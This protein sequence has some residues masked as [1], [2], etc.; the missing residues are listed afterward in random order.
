MFFKDLIYIYLLI[1]IV[2][3]INKN[4]I[5]DYSMCSKGVRL[6]LSYRIIR[7]KIMKINSNNIS[8][9]FNFIDKEFNYMKRNTDFLSKQN[10][11]K[12]KIIMKYSI[13]CNKLV[14]VFTK[15]QTNNNLNYN[16]LISY[17]KSHYKISD[18]YPEVFYYK[19]GIIYLNK[20]QINYIYNR[21]IMDIGA[22][23]GDSLLVLENYTSKV[24]YSYEISEYN[25][26]RIY[27]TMH[28]NNV[29]YTKHKLVQKGLSNFNGMSSIINSGSA[30]VGVNSKG[31]L[32]VNIT[33]IDD[34]VRLNN[35]NLGFIK[36]DVEGN[37]LELIKGAKF[38]ISNF[39]PII[40]ISIYH[41]FEEYF[42]I[43]KY[44]DSITNL[45]SYKYILANLCEPYA[46]EFT[47]MAIPKTTL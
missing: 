42:E 41:N 43:R 23:I 4:D 40:S 24:I 22:W 11:E 37:G 15:E 12:H 30:G 47:L 39:L 21:D 16:S 17:F 5:I 13:L 29:N 46:C 19:H 34:E 33:S 32:T 14:K 8:K 20:K 9:S 31:N 25:I 27:N 2:F 35:M 26:K 45:Y 18:V 38:T 36:A 7:Q 28:N 10:L 1:C 6:F 3:F 44:L